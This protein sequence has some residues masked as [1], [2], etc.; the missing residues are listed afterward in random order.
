MK[1]SKQQEKNAV[2]CNKNDSINILN[3]VDRLTFIKVPSILC[4]KD[5]SDNEY[6][7]FTKILNKILYKN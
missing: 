5:L 1:K 6:R 7:V 3:G 4:L 2:K